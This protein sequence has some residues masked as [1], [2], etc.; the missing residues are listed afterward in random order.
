MSR[1]DCVWTSVCTF[2]DAPLCECSLR[3]RPDSSPIGTDLTGELID[4]G[5]AAANE[6][7]L[8][9]SPRE[10]KRSGREER[11]EGSLQ[12]QAHRPPA[13]LHVDRHRYLVSTEFIVLDLVG[14][15]AD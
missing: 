8:D 13:P 7:R 14:G 11:G 9:R 4:R 2:M 3:R 1:C 6:A 12:H 5:A 10:L 15:L